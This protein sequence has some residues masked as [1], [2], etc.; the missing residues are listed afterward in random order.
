[1]TSLRQF[2]RGQDISRDGDVVFPPQD[3]DKLLGLALFIEGHTE[4]GLLLGP[5][6][7]QVPLPMEVYQVLRQVVEA[8]R[9]GM[10]AVVAPKNLVL[11]TQQAAEFLGVSRPTLVKL[12]EDGAIP[13]DKPN[14]HRRVQLR[15]LITFQKARRSERRTVLGRL[16]ESSCEAGLYDGSP[17]DYAAALKVARQH[18]ARS[19]KRD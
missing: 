11:T 4:P 9:Q 7:D 8:M 12:L 18:R 15:D 13:F 17:E 3:L 16:T 1:M 14:R 19:S 2:E 10:A 5:D 6:G